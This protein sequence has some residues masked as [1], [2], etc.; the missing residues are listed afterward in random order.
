[1][2]QW[3]LL[4]MP[5]AAPAII[6]VDDERQIESVSVNSTLI[7]DDKNVFALLRGKLNPEYAYL[8]GALKIVGRRTPALKVKNLISI[9][10][11]LPI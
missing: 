10:K 4:F 9:S 2:K 1:M 6:L 11:T 7:A 8:T 3:L 5:N